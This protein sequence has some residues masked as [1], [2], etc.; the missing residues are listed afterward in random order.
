MPAINMRG[1]SKEINPDQMGINTL[2]DISLDQKFEGESI[3]TIATDALFDGYAEALKFN[4]EPITI[5]VEQSNVGGMESAPTHVPCSVNGKPAEIWD[6]KRWLQVGW[7]PVGEIITTKRK[8]AE[9][10]ILSKHTSVDTQ[11]RTSP[12]KEPE[13]FM[14]RSVSSRCPVSIVRDENPKGME[15]VTRLMQGY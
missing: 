8:Y 7:L 6:G 11:V 15:W 12:G 4:E 5:R 2:N 3:Q 10:L 1:R 13:N 14:K 9:V